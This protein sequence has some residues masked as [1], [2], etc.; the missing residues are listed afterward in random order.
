MRYWHSISAAV[1]TFLVVGGACAAIHPMA[2]MAPISPI[3]A[4][5]HAAG[6]HASRIRPEVD[7][8]PSVGECDTTRG[9]R[10]YGS[11]ER[12]RHVLCAG[13]NVTNAFVTDSTRRLR[14]NPCAGV[15][16]FERP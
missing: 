3:A 12:C 2:P 10:M 9:T 7:D 4:H 14:R 8:L 15:D 6:S 5:R 11:A 16:P 1:G 13:R